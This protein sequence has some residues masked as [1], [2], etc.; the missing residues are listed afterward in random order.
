MRRALT[1]FSRESLCAAT[2]AEWNLALQPSDISEPEQYGQQSHTIFARNVVIKFLKENDANDW[3]NLFRREVTILKFIEGSKLGVTVPTVLY[4]GKDIAMFAMT[5]VEGKP[6]NYIT[7]QNY[8]ASNSLIDTL[9]EFIVA[10]DK[11]LTDGALIERKEWTPPNWMINIPDSLP[12]FAQA[13]QPLIKNVKGRLAEQSPFS[14][15]VM[16]NDLNPSNI[17]VTS[18]ES[19]SIIDFGSVEYCDPHLQFTFMPWF[20]GFGFRGWTKLF[21]A[22]NRRSTTGPF[23]DLNRI[24]HLAVANLA[25]LAIYIEENEEM[26]SEAMPLFESRLGEFGRLKFDE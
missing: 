18:E 3:F 6:L 15:R 20:H 26:R 1:D 19:V 2:N 25:C 12:K 21:E 13:L 11:T 7:D 23:V 16:H 24:I 10:F 4:T 14:M 9:A 8:L 22:V 5:R 17:L